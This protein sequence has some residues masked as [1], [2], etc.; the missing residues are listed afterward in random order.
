MTVSAQTL[1]EGARWLDGHLG[2]GAGKWQLYVSADR[3]IQVMSLL[4]SPTG[5]LANLST[6]TTAR[7]R[8]LVRSST[9]CGDSSA[10]VSFP[11][12]NL[13]TAVEEALGKAPGDPITRGELA[14]IDTL[15]AQD[16]E[17]EHLTG[18]ECATRLVNLGLEDNPISDVSP[19]AALPAL[20]WLHLGRSEDSRSSGLISDVSPLSGLTALR[21]LGLDGNQISDVSPLSGLTTL[22]HL[23]LAHNR[24]SDVSPLSRLTALES[25]LLGNLRW[26]GWWSSRPGNQISDVSPLAGLTTL[27]YLYLSGTQIS[28]ISPLANLTALTGLQLSSTRISDISPL[29]GLTALTDLDFAFNR[30]S[31]VSPL[32]RLTA[33]TDLDF[34]WNRVSNVSSLADLT[35]LTDLQLSGNRISD[36]YPLVANTGLGTGDQVE[37][38]RNPLSA[39]SRNTHIPALRARGVEVFFETRQGS[40]R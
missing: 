31:D 20:V 18:L 10:T 29:A 16:R 19:L 38:W 24:I 26:E 35:A 32:A 14:W 22:T 27:T 39:T 3:P 7:D 36:I 17:I 8:V 33:L 9:E 6:T 37:L 12:V 28:D 30:V 21:F 1:E 2:D 13:R 40:R 23:R 5:H 4:R 15:R 25:L 11:D 34:R